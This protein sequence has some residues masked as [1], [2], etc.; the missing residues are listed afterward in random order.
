MGGS[1]SGAVGV[2]CCA[3][4][5]VPVT[6]GLMGSA[7]SRSGGGVDTRTTATATRRGDDIPRLRL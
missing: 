6:G 3:S 1:G 7:A 5:A 4:T 2:G